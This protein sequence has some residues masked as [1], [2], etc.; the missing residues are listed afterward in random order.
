MREAG[1]RAIQVGVESGSNRVLK[2]MRK[3]HTI[4]E[5]RAA[6]R[7]IKDS[8][9]YVQALFVLGY[10]EETEKTLR[11]T[12]RAIRTFPCDVVLYN[13]F[14]PYPG[15]ERYRY[16]EEKEA[17]PADSDVSLFNHHSP[18]NC[19]CPAIDKDVFRARLR[20]LERMVDRI[21]SRR[22][23]RMYSSRDGYLK[24]KELGLRTGMERLF[25]F[26]RHALPRV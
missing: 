13:V 17:M 16:C 21:N 12:M 19:F 18:G 11:E 9:M 3:T 24:L 8:G 26:V 14:A 5:A 20:R 22:K 2:H 4:E 25:R 1:C 10:P 23:L 7:I 6:A 15:T